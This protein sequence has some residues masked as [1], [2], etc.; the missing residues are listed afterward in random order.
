MKYVHGPVHTQD[1]GVLILTEQNSGQA[2]LASRTEVVLRRGTTK[3][4]D[5]EWMRKVNRKCHYSVEF[6]VTTSHYNIV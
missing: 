2:V 1:V 3:V 5:L 4:W 6:S